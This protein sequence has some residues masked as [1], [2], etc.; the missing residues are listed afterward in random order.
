MEAL[1]VTGQ[2]FNDT[3]IEE[4][5]F[6]SYQP[7]ITGNINYN[8]EVRISINELDAFTFP[9]NS[10]LYIEG[11]ML[12]DAGAVP[13]KLHFINNG[14]AFL[15]RELRYELNGVVIDSVRNVGLVSTI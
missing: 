4:F 11:K 6:H 13:K 7:S 8:D 15:F 3:T 2:P 5:Q 10:Y 1:H 14:I 9:A 12:T